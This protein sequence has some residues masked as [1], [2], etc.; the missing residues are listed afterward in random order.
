[1]TPISATGRADALRRRAGF[2]LVELLMVVAIIGLAAGAVVLAA[3]DPRPGLRAEAE[4]LAAR[5][6][7]ARE[8]AVLTNRPVAI[9]LSERGYGAERYDGQTWAPLVEGPFKA[10]EWQPDTAV[11]SEPAGARVVF[12]PTGVAEPARVSLSRGRRSIG[13]AIDAA[14]EVRL[15]ERVRDA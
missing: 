11:A 8:E 6:V 1:M 9:A 3:P 4:A 7:R 15:D 2:T 13:V 14:G 5:M 12:D 10:V